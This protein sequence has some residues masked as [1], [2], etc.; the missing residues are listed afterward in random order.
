LPHP[1]PLSSLEQFTKPEF[2]LAGEG[3]LRERGLRPLSNSLPLSN[4]LTFDIVLSYRF[5]RG[6]HPEGTKG[7]SL[8]GQ[9]T[10]NRIKPILDLNT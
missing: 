10:R 9:N 5:E 8:G 2:I 4:K 1:C 7:V 3:N 6:V